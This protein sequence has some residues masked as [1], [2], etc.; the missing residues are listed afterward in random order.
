MRN[1]RRVFKIYF[2][3]RYALILWILYHLNAPF[4]I[5]TIA[6]VFMIIQGV[7]TIVKLSKED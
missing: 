6:V 3:V 1:R 7:V 2:M 5:I 4:W